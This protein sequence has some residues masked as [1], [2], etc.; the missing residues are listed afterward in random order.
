M[1]KNYCFGLLLFWT[2]FFVSC[3]STMKFDKEA[4]VKVPE[5]FQIKNSPDLEF[6]GFKA[7]ANNLSTGNGETVKLTGT[8]AKETYVFPS[9]FDL[10]KSYKTDTSLKNLGNMLEKSNVAYDKSFS[11]FGIYSLQELE[12]YKSD[13]RFITFIE[14]NKNHL[15]GT[16]KDNWIMPGAILLGTGIGL[17]SSGSIY[18]VTDSDNYMGLG[19]SGKVLIGVGIGTASIGA[20][21]SAFPAT[22]TLNFIGE[23]QIYVYDT[24]DKKVVYKDVVVVSEKDTF[25]GS[26]FNESTNK[27]EVYDYYGCIVNNAIL[28]KYVEVQKFLNNY[29]DG[30]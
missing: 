8:W 16:V 4:S 10:W 7:D 15:G 18:V 22:T 25:K 11:Y 13:K 30:N 23:Y 2:L 17:I 19:K 24:S 20:L 5:E 28:Q 26:F 6:I 27:K 9:D 29:V 3:A 12:L 1:K 14:V 21:F